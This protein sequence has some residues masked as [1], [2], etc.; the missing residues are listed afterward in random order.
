[1]R[2]SRNMARTPRYHVL[3]DGL[4]KEILT[5][6]Y[7]VGSQLPTEQEI[8]RT[9]GVSR[10]TVRD[11]LRILIDEGLV[12][13]RQGAG[14][15]VIAAERPAAFVQPLGGPQELMQYARDARL[16]LSAT[17]RRP[18]DAAEAA[19]LETP[20]HEPWVVADGLRRRAGGEILAAT[21]LFIPDTFGEIAGE[22]GSWPGA[23]QELIERRW[24]VRPA[25]IAQ[26]ITARVL[27]DEAARHLNTKSGSAALRTLRR[28]LDDQGRVIVASDSLHPADRFAYEMTYHREAGKS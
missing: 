1:M 16:A 7:P 27:D 13:R 28:Y 3:A 5:G 23:V 17:V 18:L 14:T 11:A 19:W 2:Y 21:R 6:R 25:R 9:E 26:Q 8:C 4:R 15:K 24:G 22:I 12:E 10:H 20:E